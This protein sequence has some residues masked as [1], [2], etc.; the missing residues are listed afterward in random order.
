MRGVCHRASEMRG[1]PC[2]DM[3]I[4]AQP[5]VTAHNIRMAKKRGYSR[6]FTPKTERRLTLMA[7]KVPAKLHDAVQS[8]VKR[9][10]TSVRT[11]ILTLLE[12]WLKSE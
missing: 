4:D 7:D 12:K 10:G 3:A 9:E 1:D 2:L 6:E 11:V 8:K 5:L